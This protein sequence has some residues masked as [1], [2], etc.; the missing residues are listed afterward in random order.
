MKSTL[1]ILTML[2][3]VSTTSISHA[4]DS[5]VSCRIIVNGFWPGFTIVTSTG[6]QSE[7][8]TN[9]DKL[10]AVVET[11]E[12]K[13]MDTISKMEVGRLITWNNK[14]ARNNGSARGYTESQNNACNLALSR[15]E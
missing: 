6:T 5:G 11:A 10:L 14:T 13:R 3:L 1:F 7:N 15:L 8:I 12:C 9:C 4:H 2:T